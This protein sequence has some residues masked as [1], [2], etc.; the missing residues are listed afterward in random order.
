M[1]KAYSGDVIKITKEIEDVDCKLGDVFTVDFRQSDLGACDDNLLT[2]ENGEVIADDEYV[3]IE[4]INNIHFSRELK[5]IL[6]Q[7]DDKI[8]SNFK[9]GGQGES[10]FGRFMYLV[11]KLIK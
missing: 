7:S 9:W 8:L 5:D 2:V 1:E 4:K 11:R 3:I 10:E 6:S